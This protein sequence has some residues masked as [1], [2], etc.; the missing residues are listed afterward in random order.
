MKL[1]GNNKA[2]MQG[3]ALGISISALL[4][5]VLKWIMA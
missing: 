4:A 1:D 2:Y 3:V 5:A